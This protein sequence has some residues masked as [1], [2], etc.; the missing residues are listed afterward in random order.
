[1]TIGLGA[2]FLAACL[3]PAQPEYVCPEVI[4]ASAWVN[5]MPRIGAAPTDMHVTL[6][7][8]SDQSW[9]LS[10]SETQ[11]EDSLVLILKPGGPSVVGTAA[12]KQNAPS[13][14]P[15]VAIECHGQV[16]ARIDKVTIAQ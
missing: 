7:L 4:K 9:Q 2:M 3:W 12:Y 14:L 1:M 8:E 6:R 10:P 16:I 13:P 11:P 15:R 5:R